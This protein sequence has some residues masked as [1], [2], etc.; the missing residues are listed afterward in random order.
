MAG[1]AATVLFKTLKARVKTV[2]IEVARSV[3]RRADCVRTVFKRL[4]NVQVV[5]DGSSG[6]SPSALELTRR[7]RGVSCA[8]SGM[9]GVAILPVV[10]RG[11]SAAWDLTMKGVTTEGVWLGV[12]RLVN[13]LGSGA[14]VVGEKWIVEAKQGK[15]KMVGGDGNTGEST[16]RINGMTQRI[17]STE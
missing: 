12:G 17:E 1:A 8:S 10:V 6:V 15:L 4:A 14:P 9:K 5:G 13:G 2:E 7:G 16:D 3:A 11:G